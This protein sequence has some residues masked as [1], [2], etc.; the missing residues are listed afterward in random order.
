MPMESHLCGRRVGVCR[1]LYMCGHCCVWGQCVWHPLCVR[2]PMCLWSPLSMQGGCVQSTLYVQVPYTCGSGCVYGVQCGGIQAMG[3]VLGGDWCVCGVHRC[4]QVP[5]VRGSPMLVGIGVY[6]VAA[7]ICVRGV[8]VP[9]GSQVL[10]CA[11]GV[12]CAGVGW[13]CPGVVGVPCAGGGPARASA[14]PRQP[15]LPH[16][17]P[18]SP[19]RPE[20]PPLASGRPVS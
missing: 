18:I 6:V 20:A 10:M 13:G 17:P 9:V 16:L 11:S 5:C 1:V 19:A 15:H 14:P 3:V 4:G 2:V 7:G 12:L 8:R